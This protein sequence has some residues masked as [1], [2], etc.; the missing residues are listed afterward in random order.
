MCPGGASRPELANAFFSFRVEQFYGIF[1]HLSDKDQNTIAIFKDGL[2]FN[3]AQRDLSFPNAEGHSRAA[4]DPE[5][6]SDAFGQK[7]A[8]EI[9]D[10]DFH[11]FEGIIADWQ[12]AIRIAN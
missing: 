9:I 4:F 1:C 7:N 3:R 2:T 10:G 11:C 6:F 5:L 12:F 8:T